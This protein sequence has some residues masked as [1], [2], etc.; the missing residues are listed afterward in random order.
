M[1]GDLRNRQGFCL[2]DP[3]GT[4]YDDM[5]KYCASRALD[6]DIILLDLARPDNVIGFNPFQKAPGADLM[7]Q[8]DARVQAT[9]HAWNMLNTEQT[10]TLGRTLKLI[11]TV[12]LEQNLG[13]GQVRH[14]IDFNAREI[15]G[16]LIEKLQTPLI[17]DE[18]RELQSMR[19]AADW[20][21]EVLSA[22]NKLFAFLTSKSF[23]RFMGV[24]GRTL[25]IGQIM[26]EGKV[27][28]VNLASSD[29]FSAQNARVFGALLINEFFEAAQRREKDEYGRDPKPYYLY[30]DEFQEFIS[31]DI[32]KM[33]DR[34]RKRGL[35]LVCAH[36]RFAQLDENVVDAVIS[37]SQIK[38]VFGGL[39]VPNAKRMAEE[40]FIGKLDP[41]KIKVA[42]YQT[43]FWPQY[44]RDKVYT[45]GSSHA[46][47]RGGSESQLLATVAG[48]VTGN[49]FQ[50]SD[51]FGPGD[52]TG[53][54][55]LTTQSE[56]R[57]VSRSQAEAH[58][59]GYTEAEADI[60]ILLPVPFQELSSLQYYSLEEQLMELTA[61]LKQQYPRH[62]FIKIQNE[63]TE[64]LL[65]PWFEEGYVSKEDQDWYANWLL[66]QYNALPATEVDRLLEELER[67]LLK[68][69]E[70]STRN[71][72]AEE[73]EAKTERKRPSKKKKSS[74]SS[75]IEQ[76]K[77]DLK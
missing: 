49:F 58:M 3:E 7:T 35:F 38:A 64:P 23:L 44:T 70:E 8:V 69:V 68:E 22:K 13:L 31:L 25:D 15:R 1:R 65:V 57:A 45:S 32:A 62:C 9:M 75:V 55:A 10:P 43:K 73:E 60:P 61:A 47:T 33:F 53:T 39:S 41:R 21:A 36:Q 24:P 46:S 11:Y 77:A 52:L 67:A 71:A 4:L 59:D 2:I 66:T 17:Q 18:W 12:M 37:N 56:S 54:S 51:W 50:P 28:L 14:L 26:E 42:I 16:H 6:R 27:L 29:R 20:R 19:R 63:D 48:A 34:A 5:L 74:V 40:L 76:I 72:E 30:V